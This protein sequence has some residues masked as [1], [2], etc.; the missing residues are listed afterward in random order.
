MAVPLSKSQSTYKT[1][2]DP[3]S[4]CI[5]QK[6][7][8]IPLSKLKTLVKIYFW[9]KFVKFCENIKLFFKI[10]IKIFLTDVNQIIY[11]IKYCLFCNGFEAQVKSFPKAQDQSREEV[12]MRKCKLGQLPYP[13][14]RKR[15]ERKKKREKKKKAL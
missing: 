14:L 10:I 8:T 12:W 5:K 7:K 1:I 13:I 6:W 2:I 15:R 11:F 3:L 4:L 9:K